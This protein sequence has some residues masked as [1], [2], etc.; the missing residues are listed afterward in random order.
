MK[1]VEIPVEESGFNAFSD[2]S[3]YILVTAGTVDHCNTL[4]VTWGSFG[5]MWRRKIASIYIRDSRYTK[6]F[7]DEEEYFTL[8]CLPPEDK[9][10]MSYMGSHSG[11][12]ENK[13]EKAGLHPIDLDGAAGIEEANLVFVCR[14]VYGERMEREKYTNPAVFDEWDKGKNEGNIHNMYIGEIVKVYKKV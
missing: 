4:L 5:V 3:R 13:Y 11:R 14:K 1:F 7:L 8:S 12:D 6:K 10:K 2:W 9:P